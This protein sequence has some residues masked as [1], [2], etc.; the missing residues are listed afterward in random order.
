MD[1]DS[2]PAKYGHKK[3]NAQWELCADLSG[4]KPGEKNKKNTNEGLSVINASKQ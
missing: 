2:L 1:A 4:H 3:W